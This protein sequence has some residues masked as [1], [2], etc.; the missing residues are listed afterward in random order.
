MLS[1]KATTT[2][3]GLLLG[4]HQ[5]AST[6]TIAKDSIISTFDCEAVAPWIQ[7]GWKAH[8]NWLLCLPRANYSTQP[9]CAR[10]T[11]SSLVWITNA[12]SYQSELEQLY[13]IHLYLTLGF[14]M[15]TSHQFIQI[16]HSLLC[17]FQQIYF[18]RKHPCCIQKMHSNEF[19]YF[20]ANVD[21][22]ASGKSCT[23][24]LYSWTVIQIASPPVFFVDISEIVKLL[25][26]I[27]YSTS[28]ARA[29]LGMEGKS[30]DECHPTS[31]SNVQLLTSVP[32]GWAVNVWVLA[33]ITRVSLH[34]NTRPQQ[35]YSWCQSN[36]WH[37][38]KEYLWWHL[39]NTRVY[40]NCA[41]QLANDKS[42]ATNRFPLDYGT[43]LQIEGQ[44]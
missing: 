41:Q 34:A 37:I 8:L 15:K 12:K 14:Q 1:L 21:Y 11:S 19:H 23:K 7:Q 39:W 9:N 16:I 24:I 13:I 31:T 27:F 18:Q 35:V 6:S 3:L 40:R 43:S 26:E 30:D 4:W 29:M 38:D 2:S 32:L 17:K 44:I 25:L 5:L 22:I 10:H 20:G 42:F 28:H 33:L 36:A